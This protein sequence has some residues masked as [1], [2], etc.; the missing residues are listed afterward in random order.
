MCLFPASDSSPHSIVELDGLKT[1]PV[2][3]V[4]GIEEGKEEEGEGGGKESFLLSGAMVLKR[5]FLARF[6]NPEETAMNVLALVRE[7]EG[8]GEGEA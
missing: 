5:E 8:E 7:E 3:H 6:A 2:M 1:A 4:M